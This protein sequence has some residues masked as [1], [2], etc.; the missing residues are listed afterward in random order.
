M[1]KNFL[2]I[3][4]LLNLVLSLKAYSQTSVQ[5]SITVGPCVGICIS[6]STPASINFPEHFIGETSDLI[7]TATNYSVGE[8]IQIADN[9]GLGGFQLDVSMEDLENTDGS[10]I[11]F[12]QIGILTFN[13]SSTQS[14]DSS[15]P[16]STV[17]SS[18]DKEYSYRSFLNSD[19]SESDFT[20]FSGPGPASDSINIINAPSATGRTNAFTFG[21]ALTI[22]TDNNSITRTTNNITPGNYSGNIIFTLSRI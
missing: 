16:D 22:K 11:N 21:F 7:Q 1:K 15:S 18:L 2:L 13:N 12:T 3:F 19:V 20:F 9:K 10:K 8:K 6:L 17:T 5:G 14:V 4:L